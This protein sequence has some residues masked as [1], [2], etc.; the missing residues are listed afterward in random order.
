[1]IVQKV[2]DILSRCWNVPE[3][4]RKLERQHVYLTLI[5]IGRG[6]KV[7]IGNENVSHFLMGHKLLRPSGV[8]RFRE[9]K[10]GV[11]QEVKSHLLMSTNRNAF[12]TSQT[13][14]CQINE[15]LIVLEHF[16]KIYAF[17]Y[18]RNVSCNIIERRLNNKFRKCIFIKFI[19]RN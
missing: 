19:E 9:L 12:S 14:I 10:S 3:D 6:V 8:I 11:C 1:M 2:C 17:S 15:L 5:E 4:D 7:F 18:T 13:I 16:E